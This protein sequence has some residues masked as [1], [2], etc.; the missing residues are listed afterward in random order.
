MRLSR[1]AVDDL[2]R[3]LE[4]LDEALDGPAKLTV[5]GGSALVLGFGGTAATSDID[6]Y[7]SRPDRIEEAAEAARAKTGL[8]I[9]LE[10]STIAQLPHGFD[11]RLMRVLPNL[12]KLE[13]YVLERYDL[14]ASKLVRGNEHDRQQLAQLHQLAPLELPTLLARFRELMH[15]F[16]G[17]PDEPWWALRH[18]IEETWGELAAADI[19]DEIRRMR[20]NA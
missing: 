17:S 10:D 15:D 11:R 12:K 18:F 16:V 14:A 1:Y 4:A 19:D 20:R 8:A 3:F 13:I 6:T 5:I 2:S 9:P 7:D